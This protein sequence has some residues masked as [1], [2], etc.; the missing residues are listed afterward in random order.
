MIPLLDRDLLKSFATAFVAA[1]TLT[2]VLTFVNV[3]LDNY[4]YVFG[5]ED[6]RFGFVLLYYV[7]TL[8]QQASY[9][10]PLAASASILWVLLQKARENEILAYLSCGVSPA[11]LARPF[12]T[13]ALLIS[14]CG[15][16]L[17]EAIAGHANAQAHRIEKVYIKRRKESVVTQRDQIVVRLRGER[18]VYVGLYDDKLRRM[19]QS[20]IIDLAG[21]GATL[22]QKVEIASGQLKGDGDSATWELEGVA[23]RK[24]DSSGSMT[25]Y[26]KFDRLE[27]AKLDPPLEGSLSRFLSATQ[28]PQRMTYNELREYLDL[29]AEQGRTSIPDWE[30]ELQT[31]LSVPFVTLVLG[32]LMCA[33]AIRPT[34][35][36]VMKSFGGGLVW[37]AVV[38]AVQMLLRKL[39]DSGIV[40]ALVAAWLPPGLFG[41]LG[42]FMLSRP[43]FA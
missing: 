19:E 5:G 12:I 29:Q 17:S 13:S 39:G 25:S 30:T 3:L 43:R 8:P 41:A 28:N 9:M 27:G 38:F 11:R 14:I 7:L 6:S 21:T 2:L 22:S 15:L 37:L 24:Y 16:I 18:F 32:I 33:H 34:S 26:D 35:S 10:L 1:L 20:T 31:K 23:V 36:G 40:P 4:R 42:L